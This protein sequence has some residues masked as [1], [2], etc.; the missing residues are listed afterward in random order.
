MEQ[1]NITTDENGKIKL[2]KDMTIAEVLDARPDA[3]EKLLE[4]GL[5]CGGCP[6]SQMESLEGG[7]FVHGMDPEEMI[8]ELEKK[9]NEDKKETTTKGEKQDE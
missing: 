6:M 8:T 9:L 5:M 1:K 2:D 4:M 7:A 3:A